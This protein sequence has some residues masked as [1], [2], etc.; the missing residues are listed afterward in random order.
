MWCFLYASVLH[1]L[2]FFIPRE[3]ISCFLAICVPLDAFWHPHMLL[4]TFST[5]HYEV[6]QLFC[7]KRLL[8]YCSSVSVSILPCSFLGPGFVVTVIFPIPQIKC[9]S[10]TRDKWEGLNA[11]HLIVTVQ[12]LGRQ[13]FCFIDL[14]TWGLDEAFFN[15]F[16][17]GRLDRMTVENLKA[18]SQ[19]E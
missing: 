7:T 19:F 2:H 16:S 14:K 11:L 3:I 15:F 12:Q 5:L 4:L 10:C 1:F 17:Q 9:S 13:F 18:N 6:F 8:V